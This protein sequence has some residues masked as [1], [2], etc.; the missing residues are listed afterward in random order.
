MP[1]TFK[2]VTWNVENLFQPPAGASQEQAAAYDAKLAFLAQT[3]TALDPDVIALQEVGSDAA[4]A[5]L[6][7][8]LGNAYPHRRIGVQDARGIAVAFLS[9]LPFQIQ[10][11]ITAF[12][13]AV[14]AMNITDIGGNALQAMGRGALHVRVTKGPFTTDL[15]T[16]HLKSKLLTFP[17]GAFST[18]NEDLRAR[19][20]ALA[21]LRRT[22]EAT[23]V[24]LAANGVIVGNQVH[25]LAVLGDF[26]DGPGAATTQIFQGPDGS[27][28]DTLGF[29]RPDAGDGV[30]LWNLAPRIA[31]GRR[32]SRIHRGQGELLDQIFVSEEYFPRE[33]DGDPNPDRR[34]PLE[35]DAMIETIRSIGDNPAARAGESRPDHAPVSATFEFD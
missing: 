34:L 25:A 6:Q 13:P 3:I 22:A 21:L 18:N 26:N 20:A 32:F 5:D 8:Q 27:E 19:V 12:P 10:Q 1:T 11:D 9:R 33:N 30:R 2:L 23:C 29:H 31:A 16:V 28:L 17:G 14:L 15:V 4:L 24:R 35:V 7:N